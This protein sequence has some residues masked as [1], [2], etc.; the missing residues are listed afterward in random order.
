L[1]LEKKISL[2]SIFLSKEIFFSLIGVLLIL[3][4]LILG[5]QLFIVSK[6][7]IKIGL[8][9]SEIFPY[10]LFK[11]VGGLTD[12]LII[13]YILS[14]IMVFLK[15]KKRS[16]KII[17]HTSGLSS[18]SI[19]KNTLPIFL[20][21]F[22]LVNISSSYFSPWATKQENIFKELA[23]NRPSYLSLKENQFQKIGTYTFYSPSIVPTADEGQKITEVFLVSENTQKPLTV[24]TAKN[25]YKII[26]PKNREVFMD[27]N[28]GYLFENITTE[29][30]GKI[31]QFSKY[32][33]KIFEDSFDK[34]KTIN[35]PQS[36]SLNDLII[37]DNNLSMGE[38][39]YRFTKI[40][41]LVYVIF[42]FTM[43]AGLNPRS[44]KNYSPLI[45]LIFYLFCV[46]LGI[47]SQSLIEKQ[48]LN[49]IEGFLA[50]N[51]IFIGIIYLVFVFKK[52]FL[53][54]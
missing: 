17:I 4:F 30:I 27:L 9:T 25:A 15:L 12:I 36:L 51:L 40:L 22:L 41:T 2:L 29:S 31:T 21:F 42:F 39:H 5:N 32:L 33:V 7:S 47:F 45:T 38:I 14:F 50:T 13:S 34:I 28:D 53:I 23:K 10:V 49:F 43:I 48:V 26:D 3:S 19:I 16:E 52:K 44:N 46:N 8:E 35:D 54:N 1:I 20:P 6:E 37:L 18:L 11:Y 24:I